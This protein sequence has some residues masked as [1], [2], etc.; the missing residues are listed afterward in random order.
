MPANPP[1]SS[2]KECCIF[3]LA[4]IEPGRAY[5]T[6]T[7]K[8]TAGHFRPMGE[9]AVGQPNQ[10]KTAMKAFAGFKGR[11]KRAYQLLSSI[12]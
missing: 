11:E 7:N 6:S 1:E 3:E 5:G 10:T 8:T 4:G 2:L 12:D 9:N